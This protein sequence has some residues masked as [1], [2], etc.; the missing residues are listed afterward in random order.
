MHAGNVQLQN[1]SRLEFSDILA[2]IGL[3]DAILNAVDF[4]LGGKPRV[5]RDCDPDPWHVSV[6][7]I[8]IPGGQLS[9]SFQVS[10]ETIVHKQAINLLF[11]PMLGTRLTCVGST[12]FCYY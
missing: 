6:D 3:A 2:T 4:A 10:V 9:G 5:D 8:Q 7:V 1:S 11:S 12:S